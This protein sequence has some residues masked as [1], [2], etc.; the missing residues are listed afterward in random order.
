M[1][2]KT[3]IDNHN[4]TANSC[5]TQITGLIII[6]VL[7]GRTKFHKFFSRLYHSNWSDNV[8]RLSKRLWC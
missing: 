1:K 3:S 2:Q 5:Y 8:V 4:L 6:G 7:S